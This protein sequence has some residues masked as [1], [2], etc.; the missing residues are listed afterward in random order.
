MHAAC[1]L[2]ELGILRST[3]SG[4]GLVGVEMSDFAFGVGEADC[5]GC[6]RWERMDDRADGFVRAE[7]VER[8]TE[9]PGCDCG[10]VGT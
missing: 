3:A 4:A 10:A 2:L 6:V 8:P 7:A 5:G 9:P 1:G